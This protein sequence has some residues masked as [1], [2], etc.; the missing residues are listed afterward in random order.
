M[1]WFREILPFGLLH[2]DLTVSSP[3]CATRDYF[4]VNNLIKKQTRIYFNLK[5]KKI[6]Q[7]SLIYWMAKKLAKKKFW[8]IVL[9]CL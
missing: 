1:F 4:T 8:K 9:L 3:L 7:F 5:Y 6:K 2:G